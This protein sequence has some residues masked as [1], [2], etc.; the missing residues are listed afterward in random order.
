MNSD[1][2]IK[3]FKVKLRWAENNCTINLAVWF[4]RRYSAQ[5]FETYRACVLTLRN[6]PE[7][8]ASKSQLD[9][10]LKELVESTYGHMMVT[11]L[12][13]ESVLGPMQCATPQ[14]NS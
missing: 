10:S 14:I 8:P 1:Y 3:T 7:W 11:N 5:L 12:P 2:C 6:A 4:S 9:L 13:S